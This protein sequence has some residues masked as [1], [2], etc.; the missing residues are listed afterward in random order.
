ME[1]HPQITFYNRLV[2]LPRMIKPQIFLSGILLIPALTY[3]NCYI[4][5]GNG[6]SSGSVTIQTIENGGSTISKHDKS[7]SIN[8]LSTGCSIA[9]RISVSIDYVEFSEKFDIWGS[10][11]ESESYSYGISTSLDLYQYDKV[12]F[13]VGAGYGKWNS[14]TQFPEIYW[15]FSR[16]PVLL[17]LEDKSY[18]VDGYTPYAYFNLKYSLDKNISLGIKYHYYNEIGYIEPIIDL[19]A[20][21]TGELTRA[22]RSGPPKKSSVEIYSL[23]LRWS[24]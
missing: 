6:D 21:S 16:T 17:V 2:I 13:A 5:M 9:K 15:D 11:K 10:E 12:I 18:S 3:A 1:S 4:D 22:F 23:Y 19:D 7:G 8:S 20:L 14:K 24:F